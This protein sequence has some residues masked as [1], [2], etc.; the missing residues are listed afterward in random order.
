MLN[1]E[2]VETSQFGTHTR[3][4]GTQYMGLDTE[5]IAETFDDHGVSQDETPAVGEPSP[6]VHIS[7]CGHFMHAECYRKFVVYVREL[8]AFQLTV[9]FFLK[10][11]NYKKTGKRMMN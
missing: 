2:T 4:D 1:I 5:W 10:K 8:W 3:M 11:R 9:L 6:G 7:T